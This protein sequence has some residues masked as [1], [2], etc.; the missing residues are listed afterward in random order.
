MSVDV[1]DDCVAVDA[2]GVGDETEG[3]EAAVEAAVVVFSLPWANLSVWG[4]P[5][6]GHASISS[7][8]Q[9]K[10]QTTPQGCSR[11]FCVPVNK[12]IALPKPTDH[13]QMQ[14]S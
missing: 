4:D 12:S 1:V 9:A 13:N 11:K 10:H 2:V 5:L 3:E 8:S 7:P 6:I 14:N